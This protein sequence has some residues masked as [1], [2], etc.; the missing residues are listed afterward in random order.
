MAFACMHTYIHKY[1]HANIHASMHTYIH[2]PIHQY[3]N[4]SVHHPC[5]RCIYIPLHTYKKQRLD[6]LDEIQHRKTALE[7]EPKRNRHDLMQPLEE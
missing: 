5:A 2:T 4:T 3:I 7:P 6:K 1:I